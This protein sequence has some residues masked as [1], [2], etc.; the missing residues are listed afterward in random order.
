ME[1][2]STVKN[3]VR[4]S[5]MP[6]GPAG[7]FPGANCH[8]FGIPAGSKKKGAAWEFIKWAVSKE[9]LT[10]I[11]EKH[12][13]PSIVRKSVVNSSVYREAM[14]LN[15]QDLGALF[16]QVLERGEKGDY[17]KYRTT[18]VFPQI[19]DKMNRAIEAIASNQLDA[20][21]ALKQ[22]QAQAV[23]DIK[24]AGIPIDL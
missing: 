12:G 11:V 20:P 15:G 13:Y 7:V 5:M 4:Y 1:K 9:M 16:L 21:A 2:D 24:K 3:T 18:P 8:A 19:G 10:R 6:G 22:A 23:E 14:T 17:M